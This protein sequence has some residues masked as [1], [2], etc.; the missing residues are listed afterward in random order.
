M[1]PAL[2]AKAP[3]Q[4]RFSLMVFGWAQI[5][6]D[7]QPLGVMLTGAGHLHGW[8]HSWLGALILTIPATLAGKYLGEWTLR[9]AGLE[10]EAPAGIGWAVALFSAA[11]GTFSHVLLDAF[12]HAD[13]YPRFPL[14][15]DN[16]FLF[17]VSVADLHAF[18]LYSGLL[19]AAVWLGLRIRRR[20]ATP[21]AVSGQDS[22]EG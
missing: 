8:T 17:R 1:G 3:L 18:C 10:N 9:V 4:R 16:L 5:V 12:M 7:L 14:S 22:E 20:A 19:G 15:Q 11:I 2:L 21:D 6:M 13:L